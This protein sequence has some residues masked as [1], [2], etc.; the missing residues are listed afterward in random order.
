MMS[1]TSCGS[2]VCARH[3]IHVSCAWLCVWSLSDPRRTLHLS[4][5]SSTSSSWTL[6]EQDPLC[7]LPFEESGPLANNASHSMN[8]ILERFDSVAVSE[9]MS[10]S[11]KN[12]SYTGLSV[13]GPVHFARFPN[14]RRPLFVI[15]PF[16]AVLHFLLAANLA[17]LEVRSE[18]QVWSCRVFQMQSKQARSDPFHGVLLPN[19]SSTL[20]LMWPLR[21]PHFEF[22]STSLW[23]N[24]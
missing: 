19:S 14:L 13:L 17:S 15:V 12:L 8:E 23:N 4:L 3:L 2:T 21:Y 18:F 10:S 11:R 6:M 20:I 5:P 9:S 16:W 1:H 22:F 7:S 24:L